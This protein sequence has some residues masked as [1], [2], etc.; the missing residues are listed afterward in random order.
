[1]FLRKILRG[2]A[3]DSYGIE[4]AK[5]AGVPNE[6]IRR[7]KEV[8]VAILDSSGQERKP[9]KPEETTNELTFDNVLESQLAD[10]VRALDVNTLTPLEAINELYRLKKMIE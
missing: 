3:D 8:L 2:A 1:M 10:A 4:V 6:V 5:L 9:A 7:A